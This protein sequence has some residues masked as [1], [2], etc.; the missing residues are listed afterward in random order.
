MV[1]IAVASPSFCRNEELRQELLALQQV[2]VFNEAGVDFSEDGLADFLQRSSAEVAIIG[3]EI[4][5][6]A[7]LERCPQ[8]RYIA[9]YGVGLDGIAGEALGRHKVGLGWT[10]GVNK[11]AVCELVLGFMLMHFRNMASAN[12]LLKRG[13]WHKEGGSSLAGKVAG[14]VGFGAIGGELASC[15]QSWGLELLYH[16]CLDR[17]AEARASGAKAVALLELYKH[18]DIISFHLPLGPSTYQFYGLREIAATNPRALVIN[19]ARGE[20]VDFDAVCQA[21]LEKRLGGFA[22]DVF[23]EEPM[24]IPPKY[25]GDNFYFTPHIGGNSREAVLAMGRA[26]I[27]WVQTYLGLRPLPCGSFSKQ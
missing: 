22:A 7:L 25:C 9:K 16:D 14:I 24:L 10:P 13:I 2:V 3:R 4:I 19:T 20:I 5:S 27:H 26:A 6:A 18:A 23:P 17:S 1:N 11:R 12:T 15:L 8:L 21:V